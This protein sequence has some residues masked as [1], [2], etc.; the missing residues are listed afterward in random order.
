[1][2]GGTI[3]ENRDACH[4]SGQ[5][6]RIFD[7]AHAICAADHERAAPHSGKRLNSISR[8]FD[9]TSESVRNNRVDRKNLSELASCVTARALR[10]PVPNL[11]LRPRRFLQLRRRAD[12][13][14]LPNAV[15]LGEV[16]HVQLGEF[17]YL[18]RN[19]ISAGAWQPANGEL[20]LGTTDL[21]RIVDSIGALDTD[22]YIPFEDIAASPLENVRDDSKMLS[23]LGMQDR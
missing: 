17:D 8:D 10:E 11:A 22:C 5:G 9:G 4:N 6:N 16:V 3:N 21:G 23:Y 14:Q 20:R 19:A 13:L 1:M 12:R 2:S 15:S 7:R 18:H